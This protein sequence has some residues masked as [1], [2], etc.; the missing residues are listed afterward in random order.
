MG[1]IAF[2]RASKKLA[3]SFAWVSLF[4]GIWCKNSLT[5]KSYQQTILIANR[6]NFHY[7]FEFSYILPIFAKQLFIETHLSQPCR[8]CSMV[9]LYYCISF[10]PIISPCIIIFGGVGHFFVL[11]KL[12]KV[13]VINPRK[14]H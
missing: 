9:G 7:L 11:I 8:W 2:S 14:A 5:D 10:I 6:R 4:C 1:L 3:G 13:K 12:R